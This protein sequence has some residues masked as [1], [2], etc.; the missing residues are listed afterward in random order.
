M[1]SRDGGLEEGREVKREERHKLLRKSRN[2]AYKIFLFSE[3]IFNCSFVNDDIYNLQVKQDNPL[4]HAINEK[5]NDNLVRM[6]T[7]IQNEHDQTKK[8]SDLLIS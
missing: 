4:F 3:F 8:V 5:L 6:L 1:Y 7:E 2:D